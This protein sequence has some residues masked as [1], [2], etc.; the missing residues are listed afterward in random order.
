[1]IVKCS[2]CGKILSSL[3]FDSHECD[4][5]LKSCK[6]I[7]VYFRD[8]SYKDKKLMIGLGTD[9]VFYTFEVV[10]RKAISLMEPLSRRKVTDL[11]WKDKTDEDVTEPKKIGFISLE[12]HLLT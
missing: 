8:D 12:K 11:K 2:H 3:E 9:G 1:M 10:A 7:E 5:Q 6:R 4:L